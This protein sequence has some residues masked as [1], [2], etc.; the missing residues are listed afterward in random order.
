M[1]KIA[2]WLRPS[3]VH[4]NAAQPPAEQEAHPLLANETIG[5]ELLSTEAGSESFYR[6]CR[7]LNES[8]EYIRSLRAN[9]VIHGEEPPP[10]P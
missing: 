3:R 7:N 9:R 1:S 6:V 5:T 4:R 10:P 8:M 2:E